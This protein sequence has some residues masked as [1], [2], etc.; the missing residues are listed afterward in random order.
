VQYYKLHFDGYKRTHYTVSMAV[1]KGIKG[2][3]GDFENL[4]PL[5]R[6]QFRFTGRREKTTIKV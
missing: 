5:L 4:T 3:G 1:L 2:G 6:Y